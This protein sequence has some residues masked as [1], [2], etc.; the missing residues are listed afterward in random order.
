MLRFGGKLAFILP[1]LA[2]TE[3]PIA[4]A[5][6]QT[7]VKVA[8][9]DYTVTEFP[10]ATRHMVQLAGPEGA[11]M[12]TV[13]N[14]KITAY[15]N[16]PG[17]GA[18]KALIDQVWAA[19]QAQKAGAPAGQQA[20]NAPPADDPNAALRAQVA[21]LTAQTQARA[22][23]LSPSAIPKEPVL[24]HV[25][26]DGAIVNDPQLGSVIVSDNGMKYTWTVAP[27]GGK[28]AHYTAEFEGG[29]T[30]AGAGKKTLKL[31][32]G[33]GTAVVDSVSTR[34]NAT[35]SL[36][37]NTDVWKI[38]EEQGKA[39]TL[40]YESGGLRVGNYVAA[41]GRDPMGDRAGYMLFEVSKIYELTKQE[42]AKAKQNGKTVAFDTTTD[43]VQRG[44]LA[45]QKATEDYRK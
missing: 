42:I 34:A 17:G 19:Y 28:P 11:A 4:N 45:L 27:P 37:T 18:F 33:A 10:G 3:M 25:T 43:R 29:D 23:G 16:P 26:D 14:D 12:V 44:E 1:L 9:K 36:T 38:E 31:V 21:A 15:I 13:A 22:A 7:S 35:N 20:S 5:Q 30:E 8:D 40:V 41:T 6:V 39:K 2:L 24:D 32:K